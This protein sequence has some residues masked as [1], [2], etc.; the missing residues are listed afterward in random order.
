MWQIAQFF[1]TPPAKTNRKAVVILTHCT[2]RY[3]FD[4]LPPLSPCCTVDTMMTHR[5]VLCR[6]P[7]V[8]VIGWDPSINIFLIILY[9][10]MLMETDGC[11]QIQNDLQTHV[12]YTLKYELRKVRC[13]YETTGRRHAVEKNYVTIIVHRLSYAH[14]FVVVSSMVLC[15][16]P[17]LVKRTPD[18]VMYPLPSHK[19]RE[20]GVQRR[21]I[22]ERVLF[23]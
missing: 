23:A 17:V 2:S 14:G 8:V 6:G 10:S 19:H 15:F 11:W 18:A 13:A 5:R 1:D 4:V 20:L 9:S 22:Q 16:S 21:I 7:S 3:S 12:L